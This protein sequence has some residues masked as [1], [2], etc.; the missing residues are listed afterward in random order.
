MLKIAQFLRQMNL[1]FRSMPTTSARDLRVTAGLLQA[2]GVS[3]VVLAVLLSSVLDASAQDRSHQVKAV[4]LYNFGNYV[5]WPTEAG[6]T[7]K[8]PTEFVIGVLAAM[9]PVED[10]LTK[11]AAKK[12]VHGVKI[13]TLLIPDVDAKWDCQILYIPA[14]TS[15]EVIRKALKVVKEKPV[16]VVGELPDFATSGGGMIRFYQAQTMIRFEINPDAIRKADMKASSK[17]I[18][19]GRT[20]SDDTTAITS[21]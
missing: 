8:K 2:G 12:T 10:V 15:P 20:V 14:A 5:T 4:Y 3:L 7:R 6:S 1:V 18:Q 19:I 13:R 11:I 17:L 21:G 9:D 16:L